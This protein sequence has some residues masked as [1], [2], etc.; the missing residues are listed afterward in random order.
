MATT[1][2]QRRAAWG[3]ADWLGRSVLIGIAAPVV[4]AGTTMLGVAMG[5]PTPAIAATADAGNLLLANVITGFGSALVLGPLSRRLGLS[6]AGRTLALLALLVG[7]GYANNMIEA[8]FFTTTVTLDLLGTLPMLVLGQ[9]GVAW[10]LAW[11]FAPPGRQPGLR[12]AS[13]Q[14]FRRRRWT[15]W[16]WR[17]L[18]A[19]LLYVPT[20]HVFGILVAPIVLPAYQATGANL[21]VPAMSVILPLEAVRGLLSVLFVLPVVIGWRGST[22]A[23]AGWIGLVLAALG[24]WLPLLTIGLYPAELQL[25]VLL[26]VVHGLEITADAFVQGLTIAW[27]LAGRARRAADDLPHTTTTADATT[28]PSEKA[29][30]DLIAPSPNG[31]RQPGGRLV[32]NQRP[33]EGRRQRRQQPGHSLGGVGVPC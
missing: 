12:A 20:Y 2:A 5:A 13:R 18:L 24:G 9:A 6:L 21:T 30:V 19:G 8:L 1:P 27:L 29:R 14:L 16:T 22:W 32:G 10:L 33:R 23:L 11:L 26:R 25:P 4:M 15:S 3:L 31:Q 28:G 17:L 7:V